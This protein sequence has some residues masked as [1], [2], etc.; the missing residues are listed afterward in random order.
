M[1]SAPGRPLPPPSMEIDQW[2]LAELGHQAAV[3]V[4]QLRQPL[5]AVRGLVQL[6]AADPARAGA[7]LAVAEEQLHVLQAL[8]DGWADFARRPARMDEVFDLRAPVESAL[9]LLRHRGAALGVAVEA[10]L[11]PGMVVRGS[12]LAIQQAVVNL[13]QNAIEAAEGR[14]DARVSLRV[15]GNSILVEDNGPGLPL[16]VRARL[17]EPFVTT[18]ERGTGLGLPIVRALVQGSGGE[19]ALETSECGVRWRIVLAAAA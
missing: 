1:S 5:F 19:I 11:G 8:V 12:L 13:G 7:H 18:K 10:D 4:H 2:R 6:A 15:E 14:Q 3:L 16:P 9:V 17:F